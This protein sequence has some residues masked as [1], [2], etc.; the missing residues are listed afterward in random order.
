MQ[1]LK[2]SKILSLTNHRVHHLLICFL[3]FVYGM[4]YWYLWVVGFGY[5]LYVFKNDKQ[6]A[7]LT[8][9]V[10]LI[11]I[12]AFLRVPP[13]QE[14]FDSLSGEVIEITENDERFKLVVNDHKRNTLVYTEE[15][16]TIGDYVTVTGISQ[17]IPTVTIPYQFNYENY[18][19]SQKIHGIMY[20]DSLQVV[21]V[22]EHNG[23][24]MRV[25]SYINE[26]FSESK[27]YIKTF[28]LADK[29]DFNDSQQALIS[30]LGIAHLFAISGL[31]IS[32]ISATL[33]FIGQKMIKNPIVLEI[34]LSLFILMFMV[35]TAFTPSVMR[36]GFMSVILLFN[37]RFRLGYSP[38][39]VLSMLWIVFLIMNPFSHYNTGFTLTFVVTFMLLLIQPKLKHMHPFKQS[40]VISL[41][42]FL[43][44]LPIISAMFAEINIMTIVFN[45]IFVPLMMLVILP[46]TYLTFFFAF[47]EP[48]LVIGIK[49]YESIMQITDQYLSVKIDYFIPPGLVSVFYYVF[50]YLVLASKRH[51]AIYHVTFLLYLLLIAFKALLS[52]FIDVYMFDIMGDAFFIKDSHNQCNI[53]IDTG[54]EDDY[55]T[56]SITLKK[57]GIRTIDYLILTHN[58]A[59]HTGGR[60]SLIKHFNI[61]S[62]ITNQNQMAYD[63]R[64]ISCGNLD[65]FI[66]PKE[67]D[68][69]D[70]NSNA[71]VLF[72]Q[73]HEER[74]LFTGDIEAKR[75]HDLIQ[76]YTLDATILKAPHHGSITSSTEAFIDAVNPDIVLIPSHR[77]NPFNHPSDIVINRYESRNI[78]MFR[79]DINGT[80]RFR[81]FFNEKQKKSFKP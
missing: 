75:E 19:K 49:G 59:D 67:K 34:T 62:I 2:L 35:L 8:G 29:S 69:R 11:Y 41:L 27:P 40:F 5:L 50:Y 4:D 48:I 14:T 47:L 71:I 17:P 42:A 20:A 64:W 57:L 13:Y 77:D 53:V 16:T 39:D 76:N 79:P 60:D 44:T 12:G 61:Q 23:F 24:R 37:K 18:L 25:F 78:E 22:S 21:K 51:L 73:V 32:F 68:Y 31:H 28:I 65:F 3:L 74:Y 56:L 54:I 66:V 70:E 1:H 80:V 52:P 10:L 43:V 9:G 15:T 7:V 38:I 81:Y 36:A 58:H 30:N 72:M 33:F 55:E 6:L 45:L 46:L 26:N 63:N